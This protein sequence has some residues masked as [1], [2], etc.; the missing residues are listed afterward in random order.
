MHVG[1]LGFTDEQSFSMTLSRFF[2]TGENDSTPVTSSCARMRHRIC[3]SEAQVKGGRSIMDIPCASMRTHACSAGLKSSRV[4]DSQCGWCGSGF[5]RTF[6]LERQQEWLKKQVIDWNSVGLFRPAETTRSFVH[7]G[8]FPGCRNS[9]RR[10]MADVKRA[11]RDFTVTACEPWK[12]R[13]RNDTES[14]CEKY[15]DSAPS[16]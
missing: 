6:F 12:G 2:P 3:R 9:G 7:A 1:Y 16:H 5:R 8:H 14:Y 4:R 11:E 10:R 15:Y 13:R